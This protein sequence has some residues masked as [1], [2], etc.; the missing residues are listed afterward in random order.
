MSPM[1]ILWIK[2]GGLWPLQMGGRLRSFHTIAQLSR[3]HRVTV[4]TTHGPEDSPEGLAENLRGCERVESV[5]YAIPKRG[6]ARF[7]AA[8]AASWLSRYPVDLWKCRVP[9]LQSRIREAL[10]GGIDVCVA[11]FLVAVPNVPRN[12]S[13]PAVLF[14]HNVEY[15]IWKRLAEV[16]TRPWRRALLTAEWQKM[17]LYEADACRRV[18]RTI[19]VS[20]ADRAVLSA[21]APGADVRA[22]P[23]GVDTTYFHPNGTRD[24]AATL[25][26]TGSMDWYPNEDAI[27]HFI[28]TILPTIRRDFPQIS[29]AVVG[30]NPS[31]RVKRA[32]AVAGVEVTGTVPDIRPYVARAAVYVVP[33]RVGGGTRLKIFEALA[34]GKAV[35]A[36][37]V[38]AEGLPIVSGEHFLRADTPAEFAGAVTALLKDPALRRTLGSAGRRLVEER[39]SWATVARQFET[40]CEEVVAGHA[41]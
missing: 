22:V 39:Y 18:A 25:V 27:I 23:T 12:L 40:H 21:D 13:V 38:G 2:V 33:L 34:M 36:T 35:V 24:V 20:E 1:R 5:P 31:E 11:D 4:L 28:D 17:R 3:R 9:A 8:L 16:E 15:M 32:A 19:A 10:A 14:E 6:S 29:L 41:R 7:A 37:G 26:F 30:R